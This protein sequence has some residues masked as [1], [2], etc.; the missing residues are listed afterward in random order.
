MFVHTPAPPSS[1]VSGLWSFSSVPQEEASGKGRHQIRFIFMNSSKFKPLKLCLNCPFLWGL[2]R[3][4]NYQF[5]PPSLDLGGG[6]GGGRDDKSS[7]HCVQMVTHFPILR[8]NRQKG[9]PS[10][11]RPFFS[12]SL[13][14]FYRFSFCLPAFPPP[15]LH[16][17]QEPLGNQSGKGVDEVPSS[18]L[19]GSI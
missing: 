19:C 9:V 11:D 7:H 2:P 13:L 3:K 4:L 16:V 10:L 15:N 5:L 1:L 8:H 14:A 18:H 6:A 17:I 12:P